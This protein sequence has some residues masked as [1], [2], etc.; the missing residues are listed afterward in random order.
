MRWFGGCLDPHGADGVAPVGARWLWRQ[1]ALWTVG[2]WSAREVRTA[3]G[4]GGSRLVV[5]GPCSATDGELRGLVTGTAA[6]LGAAATAWAGAYTLVHADDRGRV[7][8]V[9]DPSCACPIYTAR[10]G[11]MVWASSARALAGLTGASVDVAWLAA[12][13]ADPLAPVPG[14]SPWS[15]IA[16]MPPGHGLTTADGEFSLAPCW[17]PPRLDWDSAVTRLR[18]TLAAAVRLRVQDAVAACDLA[19]LD[20]STLAALA[21]EAGPVVAVTVHPAGVTYGGDLDYAAT[22]AAAFPSTLP[23]LLPLDERHLPYA[24]IDCPLPPTDEPAPSSLTWAM[25]S[26]Q[27]G[28]LAELGARVHLTGDGGDSLFLA[29]PTYLADLARGGRWLRLLADTAAWARLRRHSPWGLL[30]VAATTAVTGLGRGLPASPCLP[31]WLTRRALDA[32]ATVAGTPERPA[33]IGL[34]GAALLAEARFVARSAHTE[35]QLAATCGVALHNPYLD[36]RVLDTVLAVPAQLRC[37]PRVY[38]PILADAAAGLL[39][40]TVRTRTTK[41][42]FVGDHHQ[43][44]R[45]NLD[46]VLDLPDGHLAEHG[47]IEPEP[48]RTAIRAAGLGLET[49]W[50]HLEPLLCAELWLRSIAAAPAVDWIRQQTGT[51]DPAGQE[52]RTA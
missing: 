39:P 49:T 51:D 42:A 11:S 8:I 45:A 4:R 34:A 29:P 27:L 18:D 26:A 12:H 1:P 41:G 15:G 28:A 47:L 6:T 13:L 31:T 20:S 3:T 25:L 46:A 43:G 40:E 38:K 48:V 5:L 35:A 22:T 37:S 50:S 23:L 17:A 44:L 9:T 32:A 30:A 21:A 24:R 33:G 10:D 36:S 16:L 19:G 52:T 14:R 7:K 2:D